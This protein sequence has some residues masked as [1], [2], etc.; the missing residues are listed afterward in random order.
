VTKTK[1]RATKGT[2]V[3]LVQ[4]EN[5]AANCT[6][7]WIYASEAD[8]ENCAIDLISDELADIPDEIEQYCTSI[9][10]NMDLCAGTTLFKS[11]TLE[12]PSAATIIE[13]FNCYVNDCRA[14]DGEI[15]ITE[16]EVL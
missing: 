15:H 11:G 12:A 2:K 6:S 5:S 3:F 16:K 9:G 1:A 4:M 7:M 8:A 14:G 10:W 13:R